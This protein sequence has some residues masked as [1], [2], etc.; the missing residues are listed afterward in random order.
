MHQIVIPMLSK[1]SQENPRCWYKQVGRVQQTITNTE[2]RSTKLS[3]FKLLTGLDMR[4]S[5]NQEFK[6]LIKEFLIFELDDK[7]E[8]L[9]EKA[10]Q[11]IQDIQ[12]ENKRTF[13]YKRKVERK[14]EIN[15]LV[16]IKRTQYG[17]GL[18][19]KGKY[20]GPYKV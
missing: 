13:D 18:K 12:T 1:L 17:T 16:A 7:R 20:L 6:E 15:D 19:L 9:R 3:P 8:K 11:Y 4:V 5:S 14:F 10:R 2:P